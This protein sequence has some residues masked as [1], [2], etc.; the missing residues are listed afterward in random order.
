MEKIVLKSIGLLI[1]VS[2]LAACGG[3]IP[4]SDHSLKH[5]SINYHSINYHSPN[6]HSLNYHSVNYHSAN[7]LDYTPRAP[8]HQAINFSKNLVSQND[9]STF[10]GVTYSGQYDSLMPDSRSDI[11]ISVSAFLFIA[12]YENQNI[13]I[14]VNPEF[15]DYET[16][17]QEA[18]YYA[19][20]IGRIPAILRDGI[21]VVYLHHGFEPVVGEGNYLMIYSDLA[22]ILDTQGILEEI[23]IRELVHV[24]LDPKIAY[25]NEWLSAQG[26]DGTTISRLASDL[27]GEDVAESFL[28]YL[29]VRYRANRVPVS[30]DKKI[31]GTIPN[32]IDHLDFLGFTMYPIVEDRAGEW[33]DDKRPQINHYG[34]SMFAYY[35]KWEQ[36]VSL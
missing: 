29:A 33:V 32:R 1:I 27:G 11:N 15:G 8:Y 7:Y 20:V 28:A 6:Y 9:P 13:E 4:L 17:K 36:N 23:L 19:D 21:D 30:V 3:G 22:D 12:A 34:S 18:M 35:Q 5:R 24:S 10:L 16:A 14:Y 2:L 31:L 25:T 26:N